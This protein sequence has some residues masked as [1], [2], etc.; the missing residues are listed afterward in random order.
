MKQSKRRSIIY[1]VNPVL[2]AIK[3]G[4]REIQELFIV[5]DKRVKPVPEILTLASQKRIKVRFIERR[6]IE[7]F[8]KTSDHQGILAYCE[9]FKF[10]G[11]GQLI[12]DAKENDAFPFFLI[13]DRITDPRN[14]GAILRTGVAAGISGFII[15]TYYSSPITPVVAKASAG[16]LEYAKVACEIN[17]KKAI[18]L[19]KEEGFVV[20]GTDE[21]A[22]VSYTDADFKKPAGLIVGSEGEGMKKGLKENC[23]LLISIPSKGEIKSLNVAQATAIICFEALR[24]RSLK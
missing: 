7:R 11:S 6:E 15:S 5:E 13:L 9:D 16:A 21:D 10:S 12:A 14:F 19:L 22:T 8:A 24:Q 18:Y 23:D 3:A 17:L 4:K 1:G 2:E 20:Y